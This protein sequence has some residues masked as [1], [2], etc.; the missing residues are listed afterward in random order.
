MNFTEDFK[1]N[2]SDRSESLLGLKEIDPLTFSA[3]YF[4]A[5]TAADISIDPNANV[6]GISPNNYMSEM[7]KPAAKKYFFKRL[8]DEGKKVYGDTFSLKHIYNGTIYMHDATKV[9]P[10]CFGVS[11][12][13]IATEGRPYSTLPAAPPKRLESFMGQLTEFVMDCSQ[14]FA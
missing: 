12:T 2:C 13:E 1:L 8:Y 3:K 7:A 9:Q 4:N 11:A 10:Y 6:S 5:N 14:E